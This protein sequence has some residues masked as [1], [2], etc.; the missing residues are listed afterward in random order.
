[1][2]AI[3]SRATGDNDR[4]GRHGR[5]VP[6]HRYASG[7][8]CRNQGLIGRVLV[9]PSSARPRR[10][11]FAMALAGVVA[12]A[13]AAIATIRLL[14]RLVED[15]TDAD[16]EIFG[17][18]VL[19]P[20]AARDDCRFVPARHASRID[21]M[22]ALRQDRARL[23]AGDRYITSRASNNIETVLNWKERFAF[24]SIPCQPRP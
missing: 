5:G 18:I 9:T 8:I 2:R 4:Q 24:F 7:N 12:G 22:K 20:I 11:S 15:A 14:V 16:P 17:L 13:L 19:V 1:M 10:N 3:L 21:P 6:P 23:G